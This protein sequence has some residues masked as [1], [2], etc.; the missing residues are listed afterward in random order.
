MNGELKMDS[1][2]AHTGVMVLRQTDANQLALLTHALD[3][4]EEAVYLIDENA[5][6]HFVN[7]KSCRALNCTRDEILGLSIS[8]ISMD[9][10]VE[11]WNEHWHELKLKGS[12]T[13]E[14][15]HKTK[16]G[17]VF[18]VEINA[19]F[20][21][22]NGNGYNLSLVR[23]ITDRKRMSE[24]LAARERELRTLTESSPG[25]LGSI[26]R[27]ANGS[28]YMPYVSPNIR[29]LFGLHPE[30]VA[31]DATPI[32]SIIHPDDTC[33]II[34]SITESARTMT[35]WHEEHRILHPTLGERWMEGHTN[36]EPH[37]DGGVVWYGYVHD[38]TERKQ[39]EEALRDNIDELKQTERHLKESRTQLRILAAR[40]ESV[41][42]EESQHLAREIHDELG[43]LLTTIQINVY[44][45]RMQYGTDNPELSAHVDATMA[46]VE[47][48][49]QV[50]RDV[51][52]KLRPV[53]LD[54][55]VASALEWLVAGFIERTGVA[56]EL[57]IEEGKSIALDKAWETAIFRIVQESLTNI[58]RHAEASQVKISLT[59]GDNDYHLEI[60]DNGKGFNPDIRKKKSF[61]LLGI[62]ERV[63]I[64]GGKL[65]IVSAPGQGT[66]L[67][68]RIPFL[69]TK[70][71]G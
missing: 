31:N 4:V 69:Q 64:A 61:G 46:N 15:Y 50:V 8:D 41:R 57:E 32:L 12:L 29:D 51:T 35:P 60:S 13:F 21:E 44:V 33:R 34:D 56:C 38:I 18:P 52:A 6:F 26:H 49:I 11:R 55:G 36:P 27:R 10:P 16:N 3:R 7:E 22:F 58:T 59:Y 71:F 54:M 28:I 63:W 42:E 65:D 1:D 40:L 9:Y 5:R 67:Q 14:A 70:E 39:M 24:A 48:T 19:S 2:E 17:R 20:L 53:V 45:L 68:I 23:D 25:I 66:A 62:R 37:P 47:K 43:Q 30:D